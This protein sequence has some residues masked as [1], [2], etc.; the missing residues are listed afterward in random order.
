MGI[1]SRMKNAVKSKANSAIDDSRDPEK[2]LNLAIQELDDLR[3]TALQE[4]VT[5]KA[6]AKQMSKDIERHENRIAE[7]EKRAV[8]AVR[9]GDDELAKQALREK[10]QC[11]DEIARIRK[12]RDEAA[13]YA[14]QLNRSRKQAEEKLRMLKL[15]KGSLATQLKAA[16]T[17]SSLGFDNSLFDKLEDAESEIDRQSIEAEVAL[18]LGEELSGGKQ[19]L[20]EAEFD[21]KLREAGGDDA[22]AGDDD[23]LAALKAKMQ[24]DKDQ[25]KLGQ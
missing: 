18:S 15:R 25:K 12:D 24:A 4:L 8:A 7:W 19:N 14:V 21:R 3:K 17:G 23:P 2:E 13:G 9:A 16:R 5:Y 11:E 1:L 22:S 20:S 10:K 6:T